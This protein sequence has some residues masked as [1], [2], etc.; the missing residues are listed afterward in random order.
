ME[1]HFVS[2]NS[3]ASATILDSLEKPRFICFKERK[4]AMKYATYI[5]EHKAKFGT[6]PEVNLS[7]PFVKVRLADKHIQ[8][9]SSIFM[10]LLEITHR[11]QDD[12]DVMSITSGVNYFYCHR[13]D[14][15]DLLSLSMSGQEIDGFVNELMFIDNLEYNLKNM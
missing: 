11:D 1:F 12:L 5:S 13:F 10:D 2:I 3:G 7:T 9:E 15:Q 6:W 8:T 14:Y 4:Y